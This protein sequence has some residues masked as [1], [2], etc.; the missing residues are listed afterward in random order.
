[1]RGGLKIVAFILLF[2]VFGL[3]AFFENLFIPT[4]ICN[5]A[6]RTS[7]VSITIEGKN[8]VNYCYQ[9]INTNPYPDLGLY[10]FNGTLPANSIVCSVKVDNVS[11]IVRDSN[12]DG[13][14]GGYFCRW[15]NNAKNGSYSTTVPIATSP[16]YPTTAPST[17]QNSAIIYATATRAP[18]CFKWSQITSSM[19]GRKVCVYGTVASIYQTSVSSTRIK[20]T[21][22]PN[23]FFLD[24][25]GYIYPDLKLGS[26][27]YTEDIV[28]QYDGIPYMSI[29]VLYHCES[30]MK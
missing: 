19:V 2:G 30:W 3:I 8:I 1:M 11:I 25:V 18:D 12:P 27:A 22:H 13:F 28:R 9:V 16:R 14:Q 24:D 21:S 29:S 4:Q 17:T 26:C 10:L 6:S 5:I 7:P 15:L 23:S 20:F